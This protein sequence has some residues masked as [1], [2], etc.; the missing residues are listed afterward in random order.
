MV[1][2]FFFF[3]DRPLG[4]IF[5][6]IQSVLYS[7][8]KFLLLELVHHMLHVH[9]NLFCSRAW[10]MSAWGYVIRTLPCAHCHIWG[11]LSIALF[12]PWILAGP[13]HLCSEQGVF[14]SSPAPPLA[15]TRMESGK[16]R[17]FWSVSFSPLS[18]DSSRLHPAARGE[19]FLSSPVSP[20]GVGSYSS[21]SAPGS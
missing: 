10:T 3:P 21:K 2:L 20:P 7:G 12:C 18:L 5:D 1:D 13:M 11:F 9:E 14:L 19:A 15:G 4:R 8:L 6:T 17:S 16:V